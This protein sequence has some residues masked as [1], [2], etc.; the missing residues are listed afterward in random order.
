MKVSFKVLAS[1]LTLSAFTLTAQAAWDDLPSTS[2]SGWV[3]QS[4][5]EADFNKESTAKP[6]TEI[7]GSLSSG[8]RFLIKESAPR[9][10]DG[11]NAPRAELRFKKEINRNQKG[12]LEAEVKIE[13][14]T[15][16]AIIFQVKEDG[17]DAP[18]G[19]Q[20]CS[21]RVEGSRLFHNVDGKTTTLVASIDHNRYYR[22][23][24][25]HNADSGNSTV[26]VDGKKFAD[27]GTTSVRS[28][29]LRDNDRHFKCGMYNYRDDVTTTNATLFRNMKVYYK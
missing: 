10:V 26:W 19:G 22:I 6:H 4:L 16:R 20:F 5:S 24:L 17:S 29:S 7:S 13:R 12:C 11:K 3:R 27:L 18:N 8:Y 28:D 25:M 21:L 1:L 9:L 23:Y 15:S 14:G 2:G